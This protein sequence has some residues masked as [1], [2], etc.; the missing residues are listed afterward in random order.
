MNPVYVFMMIIVLAIIL[1]LLLKD[2]KK[3]D[4][5]DSL[6]QPW[7]GDQLAMSLGIVGKLLANLSPSKEQIECLIS[8]LSRKMSFKDFINEN[9]NDKLASLLGMKGKWSECVKKIYTSIVQIIIYEIDPKSELLPSC[10]IKKLEE[11][12]SP[13]ELNRAVITDIINDCKNLVSA[14]TEEQLT[15]TF[16]IIRPYISASV[17]KELLNCVVSNISRKMPFKEFLKKDKVA[18]IRDSW[19]SCIIRSV[20]PAS[21]KNIPKETIDCFLSELST[22]I[23]FEDFVKKSKADQLDLILG[24]KGKWSECL[25]KIL[26]NVLKE[27]MPNEKCNSCVINALEVNLSPSDLLNKNIE[28]F[29]MF[30]KTVSTNC[31]KDCSK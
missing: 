31:A 25:K 13:L 19:G 23:S 5:K 30:L 10:V 27:Q 26:T 2:D 9:D 28:E 18:L 16:D 6:L 12:Y 3:D 29:Q 14:W 17:S 11:N 15:R 1:I 4:K 24:V 7:T 22:K 8:E 21:L 20:L